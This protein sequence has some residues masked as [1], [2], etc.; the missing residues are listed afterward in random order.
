MQQRIGLAASPDRH[1]QRIGDEL[2]GH[3]GLHRPANHSSREQVDDRSNI[4]PA[5]RRPDIGEVG[6]SFSIGRRRLE[7]AV[8]DVR[9]D[10]ASLPLTQIRRQATPSWARFKRL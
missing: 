3:C 10:G 2:R 1:H 8:E 4:E 5:L 9:S 6:D 7:A